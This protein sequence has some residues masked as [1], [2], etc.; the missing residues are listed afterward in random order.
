ML[1]SH[2]DYDSSNPDDWSSNEESSEPNKECF[3]NEQKVPQKH[4]LNAKNYCV[5][6]SDDE[7]KKLS[8]PENLDEFQKTVYILSKGQNIQKF[9]VHFPLPPKN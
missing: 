9:A 5:I 8:L 2:L 6:K 3:K 7:I 4:N 1:S